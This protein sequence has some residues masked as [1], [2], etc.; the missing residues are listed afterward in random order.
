MVI[1]IV[2]N[3]EQAADVQ[4]E[5]QGAI[6]W[7]Y[8]ERGLYDQAIIEFRKVPENYPV[9]RWAS[10]GQYWV[11]QCYYKKGDFEQAMIEYRKVIDMYPYS[12]EAGYAERKIALIEGRR[13]K[14]GCS[15]AQTEK[16]SKATEG[17][18][19]CGPSALVTLGY[20]LGINLNE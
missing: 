5:V 12:K 17:S 2:P 18:S 14:T 15:P 8:V 1:E 10:N 11:G 7:T 13:E 9:S 20:L 3:S 16:Q 4:A 19:G 6:G